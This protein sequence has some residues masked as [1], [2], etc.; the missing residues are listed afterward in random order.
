MK[1][2]P[3]CF[4]DLHLANFTDE[5]TSVYLNVNGFVENTYCCLWYDISKPNF[6]KQIF[7]NKP[8]ERACRLSCKRCNRSINRLE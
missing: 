5:I 1:T 6:L 2:N 3:G 4:T 8:H 7:M